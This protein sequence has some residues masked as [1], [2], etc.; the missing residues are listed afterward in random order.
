L[1][2]G[3]RSYTVDEV[4]AILHYGNGCQGHAN[5]LLIL[6]KALIIAKLNVNCNHAPDDCISQT[7][8]DSDVVIGALVIPPVGNGC[9]SQQSTSNLVVIFNQYN[10]GQMCAPPCF[11]PP[12][13]TP[14]P[15]P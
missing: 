3:N 9:M 6:A 11:D 1:P 10:Y 12:C 7:I 14:T 15:T 2:L 8:A 13:P 5:G 4:D